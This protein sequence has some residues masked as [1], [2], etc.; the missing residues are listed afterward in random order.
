MVELPRDRTP[1]ESKPG[2]DMMR[3]LLLC[4]VPEGA[5][6]GSSVDP[7]RYTQAAGLPLRLFS[8]AATEISLLLFSSFE[9]HSIILDLEL[10]GLDLGLPIPRTAA[11]N[12]R[13]LLEH[14]MPPLVVQK[15]L[16]V[17]PDHFK[18]DAGSAV[19]AE[20]FFTHYIYNARLSVASYWCG[21]NIDKRIGELVALTP[22]RSY[23]GSNSV[24]T[25]IVRDD[26]LPSL[27]SFT[28]VD[29]ALLLN[30]PKAVQA[31]LKSSMIG[32]GIGIVPSADQD[33]AYEVQNTEYKNKLMA[34]SNQRL[35]VTL[36]E[37]DGRDQKYMAKV[38]YHEGKTSSIE[39]VDKKADEIKLKLNEAMLGNRTVAGVEICGREDWTMHDLDG[40]R[41]R[42]EALRSVAQVDAGED[43]DQ[44]DDVM[45]PKP[46]AV[47]KRPIR[48]APP[49]LDPSG[50]LCPLLLGDAPRPVEKIPALEPKTIR[51]FMRPVK[52]QFPVIKERQKAQ[53]LNES[54]ARAARAVLS[55]IKA[56]PREDPRD[57]DSQRLILIHGPPGTGKTSLIAACCQQWQLSCAHIESTR[58]MAVDTIY[59]CCQSNVAVKNIA[60][61]LKKAGVDFKVRPRFHKHPAHLERLTGVLC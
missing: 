55:P 4:S 2:Y 58:E 9:M 44:S 5:P 39:F 28:A 53:T 35:Y 3:E 36:R 59:A 18:V 42:R 34:N 22:D 38:S 23:Q 8:L 1:G 13:Q 10:L 57:F 32:D 17:R 11:F 26:L 15:V 25:R 56:L 12:A 48:T 49:D 27:A 54:Q 40:L 45:P 43:Q 21:V 60:E 37:E 19:L 50:L 20:D 30:K 16:R 31:R 46:S 7:L 14:L 52:A 61:S 33:T 47:Q 29:V 51:L 6:Q 41:W 24:D